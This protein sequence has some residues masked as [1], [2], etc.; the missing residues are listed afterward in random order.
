MTHK[1]SLI[2]DTLQKIGKVD[3]EQL[4][5]EL[6]FGNSSEGVEVA[7]FLADIYLFKSELN[8]VGEKQNYIFLHNGE[9]ILVEKDE[10]YETIKK[11]VANLRAQDSMYKKLLE[12]DAAIMHEYKE[13]SL[14]QAQLAFEPK[15]KTLLET[16]D[17]LKSML[18][19]SSEQ[20]KAVTETLN[21]SLKV[22]QSQANELN[23]LSKETQERAKASQEK[24]EE[25]SERATV[26]LDKLSAFIEDDE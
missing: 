6:T 1:S 2:R 8:S 7:L 13:E 26:L 14:R 4:F 24:L 5:A 19:Q 9:S 20:L 12:N 3:S 18:L 25:Q 17:E 15:L 10:T 22:A 16:Q 21:D 11:R 23:T